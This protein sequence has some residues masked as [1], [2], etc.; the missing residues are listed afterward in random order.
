MIQRSI[1]AY[2]GKADTT[3][4]LDDNRADNRAEE[5]ARNRGFRGEQAALD[6]GFRGEQAALDR[7]FRGDQAELDRNATDNRAKDKNAFDRSK[8][9]PQDQKN[10]NDLL[11]VLA[12]LDASDVGVP[13]EFTGK[14]DVDTA[15]HSFIQNQYASQYADARSK[16]LTPSQADRVALNG[17]ARASVGKTKEYST[18]VF[19]FRDKTQVPLYILQD[20]RQQFRKDQLTGEKA[21]Q[22]L[23]GRFG[24][25]GELRQQIIDDLI[26]TSK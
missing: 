17:L 2:Q 19:G 6:R 4:A 1:A 3:M 26:A 10:E 25:Q 14:P 22:M 15:M 7:G 21:A 18:G 20:L 12:P 16:G 24:I 5:G 11:D 9:T 8:F 23:L 13:V